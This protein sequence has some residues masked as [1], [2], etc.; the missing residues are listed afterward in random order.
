ME[1]QAV[2][3]TTPVTHSLDSSDR[4][5]AV[6]NLKTALDLAGAKQGLLGDM[7]RN[8]EGKSK[9]VDTTTAMPFHYQLV[10][11]CVIAFSN[12]FGVSDLN[13]LIKGLKDEGFDCWLAK[14]PKETLKAMDDA[15]K[16]EDT[17]VDPPT[18]MLLIR[19]QTND[20][21]EYFGIAGDLWS[22]MFR[23]SAIAHLNSSYTFDDVMACKHVAHLLMLGNTVVEKDAMRY[24]V[25]NHQMS[26][27]TG[28]PCVIM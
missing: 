21:D 26:A 15:T 28:H 14:T 25:E 6:T 13:T 4:R 3:E 2:L 16:S 8:I 11:A 23:S 12:A 24:Y 7:N 1:S 10:Q 17:R 19:G 27:I 5:T 18:T 20:D 9:E 22:P